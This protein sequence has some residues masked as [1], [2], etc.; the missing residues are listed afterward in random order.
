LCV[1]TLGS[2]GFDSWHRGRSVTFHSI[3]QI[4][5]EALVTTTVANSA[6]ELRNPAGNTP[7]LTITPLA[8]RTH[9]AVASIVIQQ[10]S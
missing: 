1:G 8:G 4:A 10:L 2:R 9:P 5:G 6:L 3:L 7:T